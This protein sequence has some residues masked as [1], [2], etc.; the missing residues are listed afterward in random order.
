MSDKADYIETV[1]QIIIDL[2]LPRAQQNERTALCLLALLNLA[3]GKRWVD[4]EKP[5]HGHYASH[6]LGA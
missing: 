1:K 6:G 3:P 4:A 5:A 2:R